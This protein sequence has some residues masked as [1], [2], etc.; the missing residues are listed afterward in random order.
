MEPGEALRR[1]GFAAPSQHPDKASPFAYLL[2][3]EFYRPAEGT[4]PETAKK[5]AVELSDAFTKAAADAIKCA[6]IAVKRSRQVG[7]REDS[8]QYSPKPKI[9]GKV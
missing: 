6:R 4:D 5:A 8:Q 3:S 7:L 1:L 2:R 9:T